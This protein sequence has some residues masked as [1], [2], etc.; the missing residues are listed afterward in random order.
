MTPIIVTEILEVGRD[1]L[2][3]AWQ[4]NKMFSDAMYK[5]SLGQCD[6]PNRRGSR[7]TVT[8]EVLE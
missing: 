2:V 6:Y 8:V 4:V 3:D 7:V 5:A 1:I